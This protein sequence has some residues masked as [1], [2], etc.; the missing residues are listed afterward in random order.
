[1][2]ELPS[3]STLPGPRRASGA[4]ASSPAP[5]ARSS[6]SSWSSVLVKLGEKG[7][8]TGA[9]WAPFLQPVTW[10]EYLLPGLIGTLKAAA[11]SIVLAGVLG[12]LLGTGRLSQIAAL[13]WV[14]LGASWSSSAPCRC[15]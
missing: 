2:S 13:R 4:T 12:L 8:L 3:S 9:K 6:S 1:M 10:T 15:C 11:I 7:N 14:V 5:V